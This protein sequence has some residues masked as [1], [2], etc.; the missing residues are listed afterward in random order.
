MA[1][2]SVDVPAGAQPADEGL[3]QIL[4]PDGTWDEAS[5]PKIPPELLRKM[6]RTMLLQRLLDEKLL[7]LQRQGRIAFYGT[8]R[9]EEA[10]TVGSAAAIHDE[11][12]VFPALRQG[13]VLLFRGY[14]LQRYIGQLLGSSDDVL[15]GRM[16]PCH[17]SDRTYRVVSWSSNM[18]TQLPHAAGAAYAARYRKDGRIVMGYLGDGATSEGD[19]HT[20]LNFAGV[21]KLPVVFVCQNNQWA[22][23]V[24]VHMQT[25]AKTLAIKG[26]AYGVPGVRVDGNDILAVHAVA[27]D[28]VRRARQGEGPTFIECLT[29]R[30]G[31]HSTADDPTRYRDNAEVDAWAQ[32]DP[33]ERF[34]KYLAATGV[35][36]A[37]QEQRLRAE[38]EADIGSAISAG[39][40]AG[41]PG[42]RTMFEDV[43]AE[44]PWHLQEEFQ[45]V[46]KES[47][48]HGGGGDELTKPHSFP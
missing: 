12:W 1:R 30:M 38:L 33:I 39:E 8:C 15:K 9:G 45:E 3:L 22:I 16:Q 42:V 5:D 7:L 11:D 47:R 36:S 34:R 32:R 21:Y 18:A 10:A 13:A 24:P 6:F 4:R 43:F 14:P 46:L 25:A 28:A 2:K 41:K 48:A 37:E 29:Y 26:R 27:L 23:S 17:Y 31:A 40:K 35:Q 20:G 19:F 44:M